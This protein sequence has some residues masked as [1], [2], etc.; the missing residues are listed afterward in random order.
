MLAKATYYIN[1]KADTGPIDRAKNS[2]HDLHS[3]ADK[4]KNT[5]GAGL[6]AMASIEGIKKL[7]SGMMDAAKSFEEADR[8]YRALSNAF[9]NNYADYT[10]ATNLIQKL[11]TTTLAS[12]DAIEQMV[13]SLAVSGRSVAEIEKL[14]NAATI[15]SNVTGKDWTQA[16]N[17]LLGSLEGQ[18]RE[19]QKLFPEVKNLTDEELAQGKAVDLLNTKY[20][21]FAGNLGS[22][23]TQSVKNL[24]E[25]WGDL[26]QALG[27]F[28]S[29]FFAP[30]ISGLSQL[31]A[32]LAEL[33]NHKKAIDEAMSGGDGQTYTLNDAQRYLEEL[34]RE[35][36]SLNATIAKY[37]ANR[38][39]TLEIGDVG[40][41][42]PI[43]DNMKMYQDQLAKVNSAITLWSQRAMQLQ[44][45]QVDVQKKQTAELAKF[46]PIKVRGGFDFADLQAFQAQSYSLLGNDLRVAYTQ[47]T[48][49]ELEEALTMYYAELAMKEQQPEQ[50]QE[51][52][53]YTVFGKSMDALSIIIDDIGSLFSTGAAMFM[54]LVM[55]SAPVTAIMS[56]LSVVVKAAY[57]VVAPTIDSLL[58]P[59]VGIL[60]I[61]GQTIGKILLPAT[62]ALTP[63]IEFVTNGFVLLYNYAIKPFANAVI[64]IIATL[65]NLIADVV[66]AVLR[67]L[68]EIPFVDIGWRMQ[69]QNVQSLMLQ[70]LTTAQLNS[71]GAAAGVGYNGSNG[72]AASYTGSQNITNNFYIDIETINGT[73]R[74]AALAF[75][76]E[77]KQ[78]IKLGLASY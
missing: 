30:I 66:N 42:A 18:T 47:A 15:L 33:L 9:A 53:P 12:K 60:A 57:D 62:I 68:D 13:S 36:D 46:T 11:S 39:K 10:R 6:V 41:A 3:V 75:L 23:Y 63:I 67:A 19:L 64:W 74:E 71:A 28:T 49:R 1:G 29:D 22:T 40:V 25:A 50:E 44:Q 26:K 7:T 73:N 27:S 34:K 5:L 72:A 52:D 69:K 31:I 54:E 78:A 35:R 8:K 45:Q 32:K 55:A 16:A 70:D 4:L 56:A 76:E 2:I 14:T 24:S 77:I 61:L 48:E 17:M 43:A 21:E 58:R 51:S 20:E 38:K 59:I 37:E 65:Y